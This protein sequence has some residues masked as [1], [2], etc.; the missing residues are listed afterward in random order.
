MFYKKYFLKQGKHRIS[1]R[2]NQGRIT[3]RHRGGGVSRQVYFINFLR[4]NVNNSYVVCG[5]V[6]RI[7]K[8]SLVVLRTLDDTFGKKFSTIIVNIKDLIIGKIIK[9]YTEESLTSTFTI[10]SSYLLQ[11]LPV[12]SFVSCIETEVSKGAKLI[13]STGCFGTILQN[14]KRTLIKLPSGKLSY[15]SSKMRATFGAISPLYYKC[16]LY[17][18]GISRHLGIRPS[19]RGVAINACDHPHGGGE[20]KSRI[21]RFPV[22]PWGFKLGRKVKPKN[23]LYV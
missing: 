12:G 6:W 7:N 23:K 11:S 13:R 2:N 18:A 14:G 3:V 20:G 8:S 19:V 16:N 9:N 4:S 17:K 21:G 10:G 1:G 22:S 5:F 15:F